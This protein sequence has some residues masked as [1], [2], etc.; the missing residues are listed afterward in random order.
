MVL[1]TC[2]LCNLST[3][4]KGDYTRH[5]KTKKH[6]RNVELSKKT[7]DNMQQSRK[8]AEK[9]QKEPEKS[10]KEPKRASEKHE[11]VTFF[12]C[13]YCD[14]EFN[15]FAI[16]R[17]HEMY[18]CEHNN[19]TLYKQLYKK[20]E[21]EKTI[22]YKKI[23]KLL[24]KVG[25]TTI[26]NSQ[27]NNVQ[28]NSYGKEDLSHITDSMKTQLLKGPYGMIPKLIEAVH[29]NDDKPENKNIV[30]PN[31]N[32][33]KMKVYTDNK[34]IYKDKD[35]TITDL[36]DGKYFILDSHYAESIM[37]GTLEQTESYEKFRTFFDE[38]DKDLHDQLKKECELI[39]LNNRK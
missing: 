32:D 11:K 10:Q 17:R 7:N 24:E 9:S 20:S 38:S 28:L 4:L 14:K 22:L 12:S 35:Q 34:W 26:M 31:K 16:K 33:N 15:T 25:N 3:K 21:K 37:N 36:M 19:S 18:R 8:R 6:G 23:D 1:Y 39:L 2:K 5:L 29:F 30:L 27:T 13:E